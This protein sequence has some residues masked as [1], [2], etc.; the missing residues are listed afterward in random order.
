MAARFRATFVPKAG[1]V[2][3]GR[4]APFFGSFSCSLFR[5]SWAALRR[6]E[7]SAVAASA[8][9]FLACASGGTSPHPNLSPVWRDYLA[10]PGER[11]LAIAGDPGRG[12]WVSGISAGH[13][14]RDL[15]V[16]GA[17]AQCRERRRLRRMQAA[18][19]LYAVGDGIVWRGR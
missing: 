10:L 6:R 3:S 1:R 11:A 13:P 8:A 9:L 15:A 17:L 2:D 4:S 5:S 7:R 12:R 14:S 16:A 18:C 19:V